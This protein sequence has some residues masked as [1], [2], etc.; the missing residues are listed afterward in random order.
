MSK[1]AVVTKDDSDQIANPDKLKLAQEQLRRSKQRNA[2]LPPPE[3]NK[4]ANEVLVK[5]T[6]VLISPVGDTALQVTD[7]DRNQVALIPQV[8]VVA[9][10]WD[11]VMQVAS[12]RY[13][14]TNYEQVYH[15]K[16]PETPDTTRRFVRLLAICRMSLRAQTQKT[17]ADLALAQVENQN[18]DDTDG[19]SGLKYED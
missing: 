12:F 7:L 6:D 1:K 9:D 10:L 3:P 11:Y 19:D 13:D 14:R 4:I 16:Y 8:L 2:D 15:K 17:L 18:R 5:I